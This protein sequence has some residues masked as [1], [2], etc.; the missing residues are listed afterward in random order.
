M[1][2]SWPCSGVR[3]LQDG[4]GWCVE[5]ITAGLRACYIRIPCAKFWK[6]TLPTDNGRAGRVAG[7]QER[8]R[9]LARERHERRQAR[10]AQRQANARK[11]AK[12][13]GSS[14]AIVVIA[15]V[16]VVGVLTL[17][18]SNKSSAAKPLTT[19]TTTPAATPS[20]TPTANPT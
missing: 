17:T 2:V 11:T 16:V 3:Q 18:K 6:S 4:C 19:P 9:K 13:V 5:P 1:P 12:I 20:A 10:E 8:Q 14:A 7:K 15:A